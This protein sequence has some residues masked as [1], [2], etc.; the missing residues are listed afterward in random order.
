MTR[1]GW[2]IRIAV[3]SAAALIVVT[4]ALAP[5]AYSQVTDC[6]GVFA[7]GTPCNDGDPCTYGETCWGQTCT[8]GWPTTC[9]SDVCATRAG[10][11]TSTCTVFSTAPDGTLCDDGNPCT[12]GDACEA[13][14]C[15]ALLTDNTLR[16]SRP[17]RGS[18]V[19]TITWT[20]APGA[21][22]SD[23]VRGVVSCLPVSP[24]GICE[25][26]L[27]QNTSSTLIADAAIPP[28]GTAFWYLVRGRNG[29]GA[30]PWG[31]E[32]N[33]GRAALP[34]VSNGGCVA[35]AAASPRYVDNGLTVTDR[36]TCLEWEKKSDSQ[37]VNSVD[38][39][40]GPFL[41]PLN[42]GRFARHKNWR[43]PSEDGCQVAHAICQCASPNELELLLP[44]LC[45]GGIDPVFGPFKADDYA[46][47]TV[48]SQDPGFAL[49]S[50]DFGSGVV[51][52]V[53]GGAFYYRAVRGSP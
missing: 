4:A 42:A 10:N 41:D 34:E 51:E 23:V 16:L 1:V 5:P 26:P 49:W 46:S 30:G 40:A 43:L 22:W 50:V 28:L 38:A 9:S 48:Y 8:G 32:E 2:P 27:A 35:H 36:T 14:G 12:S 39:H 53:F 7:N 25:T 15:A 24:T 13:G 3:N 29:C 45:C 33:H 44:C 18:T 20:I 31:F 6:T 37:G 19:A 11:G 47:S 52:P 17:T 21:F